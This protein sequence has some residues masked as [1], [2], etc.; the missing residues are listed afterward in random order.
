MAR[1]IERMS[2]HSTP[3]LVHPTGEVIDAPR[4][5]EDS[6]AFRNSEIALTAAG[7]DVLRCEID[8][9]ALGGSDR[10]IGGVH[11]AGADAPWRWDSDAKRVV[12]SERIT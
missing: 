6:R 9:I 12:K 7:R 1:Y 11:L 3:L 5:A 4:T 2:R 10:W 8:W